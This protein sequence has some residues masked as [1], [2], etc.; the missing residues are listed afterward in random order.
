MLEQIF[1][2]VMDMSRS[3]S[4]I[5]LIVIFVRILLKR[6][7]KFISYMLWSVVLFRLL[8]PITLKS[9]ISPVPDLEPVFYEYRSEN[10]TVPINGGLGGFAVSNT[11]DAAKNMPETREI[12]S[13]QISTV[14]FYPDGSVK[15]AEIS[16]QERIV[17]FGKYV[18]IS[19]MGIMLLYCVISIVKIRKKVLV[20]IPF[21]GNIYMTDEIVSPFVMGIFNPRIYLPEGLGEKEQ[22]YIILHEK[23]HIRRLDHIVKPVAFAALS[24][25]WFNPFAWIAFILFCKDMEMSCD[26]AVIKRMGENIRADYSASLLTLSTRHRILK[27][28]PVDFGEGD[29]KGRIKNLAA[30]KKTKRGMVAFLVAGVVFLIVCLSSTRGISA[31]E[32]KDIETKNTLISEDNLE[33]ENVSLQDTNGLVGEITVTDN[34]APQ[35]Q[36]TVSLDITE[37]YHT[38]VGDPSNLYYID[39]NHVLWGSGR[40]NCGQL[41][42]GTQDYEFHSDRVKIAE[43]VMDVDYSQKGFVIY[44]TEDNKLYGVGNAGCGA[45]QQYDTF[46]FNKYVNEEHYYISEPYLLMEN[47]VYA[48]CGRDDVA[49]LTEDG[50]VWIWGTVWSQGGFPALNAYFVPKPQKILEHAVLVTGGWNNHAALLQDGTVWTWG[51][52]SAGNCGVAD[53]MVVSEPTMV[54]ENVVMV[55]TDRA[56]KNYPDPTAED[57]AAAWTGKLTYNAEYDNIADF[58]GIYPQLL[59]NTVIQK[60]DSS[61][62]VCGENVGKKE[63]V[64]YGAEGDYS[65]VCT[66]EFYPCE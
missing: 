43:Q 13:E 63:K 7:P 25:H 26:E 6:F 49:C 52:N 53:P 50:A 24:I 56:L 48:R 9:E 32:A 55:W 18:W 44:L 59:N 64:V 33:T 10:D 4:I 60:S 22:E 19:G 54:A 2:K 65:V 66:N 37:N 58:G 17:L 62:W 30:F 27:G 36:L 8:C 35:S 51:Y 28:L 12:P 29:T 39:E 61:Y 57:I 46:D 23:F 15:T 11:S 14:P 40:N 31:L 21:K 5:I 41:G 20:S 47:V 1:L 16:R 42:Q 34:P 3:A 38:H 45:L